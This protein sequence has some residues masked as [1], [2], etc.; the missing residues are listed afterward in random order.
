MLDFRDKNNFWVSNNPFNIRYN[1]CNDWVGQIGNYRG[2]CRFD[3]LEYGLRAGFKLLINYKKFRH[4]STPY[5][6]IYNFA[7][8]SENNTSNYL[9][10]VC[11]VMHFKQTWQITTQEEFYRLCNAILWF[12]SNYVLTH[13]YFNF[14]CKKFNL[15]WP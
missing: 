8:P 12:E 15:S 7:P 11:S 6:I 4:L 13:E 9:K 14:V 5:D 10:Y 3:S 1:Q 2:F